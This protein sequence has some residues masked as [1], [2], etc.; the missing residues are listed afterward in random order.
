ML[1]SQHGGTT[2]QKTW[3]KFEYYFKIPDNTK[4][5]TCNIAEDDFP[6]ASATGYYGRD[7]RDFCF[8]SVSPNMIIERLLKIN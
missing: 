1:Q 5:H 2:L 6:V 7:L 8:V 3:I 4:K